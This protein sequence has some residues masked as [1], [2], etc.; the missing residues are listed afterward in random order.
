M[1]QDFVVHLFLSCSRSIVS[2]FSC[3]KPILIMLRLCSIPF[4]C[5]SLNPTAFYHH[6]QML[7]PPSFFFF[8]LPLFYIT[9]VLFPAH[10]VSSHA[11]KYRHE[12][13]SLETI[14]PSPRR[15][16]FPALIICNLTVTEYRGGLRKPF[17]F[18]LVV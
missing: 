12:W 15:P 9:A 11:N 18:L 13:N 8:F 4:L 3:P 17:F 6:L 14:L 16:D 5:I 10:P 2:N 1:Y 7:S